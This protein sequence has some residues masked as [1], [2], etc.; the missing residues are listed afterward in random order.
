MQSDILQDTPS[1]VSFVELECVVRV[2]LEVEGEK[3]WRLQTKKGKEK[4]KVSLEPI[5]DE[6]EVNDEGEYIYR[7]CRS[8]QLRM[9]VMSLE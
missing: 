8:G 9:P 2:G 4:R 3:M 7:A 5:E 6:G 1:R